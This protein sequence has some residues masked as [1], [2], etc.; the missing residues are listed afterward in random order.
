MLSGKDCLRAWSFFQRDWGLK[1]GISAEPKINQKCTIQPCS[2]SDSCTIQKLA[3]P[4]TSDHVSPIFRFLCRRNN[5][6]P[7]EPIIHIHT[8]KSTYHYKFVFCL[9][10]QSIQRRFFHPFRSIPGPWINSV[11]EVPATLALVR[12]N[13]HIYY[14]SLHEKYGP[15]VRV[16][17]DELSFISVDAREEIYGLRVSRVRA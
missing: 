11:S 8:R 5:S 12:G 10:I 2:S 6:N 1:F 3:W 9:L 15:V 17:P 14:R 13:Q 7:C 4:N 16:S